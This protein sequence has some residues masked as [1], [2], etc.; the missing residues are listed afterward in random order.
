M[1]KP[2]PIA[3]TMFWL[4]FVLA[5]GGLYAQPAAPP[6][7][8]QHYD[9]NVYP[10]LNGGSPFDLNVATAQNGPPGTIAMTSAAPPAAYSFKDMLANTHG[11]VETGV[12]SRGG[13][14]VSGGVGIPVLP[15]KADLDLAAGTGQLAGWGK[16]PN[17]KTPLATY[18]QYSAGLHFHPTDDTDA[19]IGV[20]GIR[21]HPLGPTPGYAFGL[22]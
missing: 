20:T 15:G 19:Y 10:A 11:F 13:Y 7:G 12:S 2:P 14:G 21:V 8:Q 22:P 18:D 6:G 4:T 1:K 3:K 5:P 17:G 16:T 9:L